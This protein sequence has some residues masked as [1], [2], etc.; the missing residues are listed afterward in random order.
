MYYQTKLRG[1]SNSKA[2]REL[3]FTPQK[4]EW[5]RAT[6]EVAMATDDVFFIRVECVTARD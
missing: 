1:A 6:E 5:L 4:L 2:K 3:G